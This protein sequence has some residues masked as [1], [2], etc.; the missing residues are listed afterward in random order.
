MRISVNR[1]SCPPT[2]LCRTLTGGSG[3]LAGHG[4]FHGSA[5]LPSHTSPGFTLHGVFQG[6]LWHFSLNTKWWLRMNRSVDNCLLRRQPLVWQIRVGCWIVWYSWARQLGNSTYH[7]ARQLIH[8]LS[9]FARQ[10]ITCQPSETHGLS[11]PGKVFVLDSAP[12]IPWYFLLA[13]PMYLIILLRRNTTL[14]ETMHTF[15]L[16]DLLAP[17]GCNL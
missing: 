6:L 17:I 4:S 12:Q 15:G 11:R 13:S 9:C 3:S 7:C 2:I 14:S 8:F 1:E 16:L 5:V 10:G